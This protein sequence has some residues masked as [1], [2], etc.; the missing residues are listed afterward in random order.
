[1]TLSGV[2]SEVVPSVRAVDAAA[3]DRLVTADP[4]GLPFLR[5][6][7]LA[8]LEDTGCTGRQ[9]GW[10]PAHLLLRQGE[11]LVGLAPAHV[12][13]HSFGEF[14]HD[15]A[16]ADAAMRAGL[17]YYPKLVIAA[18]F[19][20]VTG[21]RLFVDPTLPEASRTALRT[22]LLGAAWD[23]ARDRNLSGVHLLFG[24]PDELA[25]AREADFA[26]RTGCQFHWRNAGE[27]DFAGFLSRFPSHRR[28]QIRRE[29]RQVAEAGV[30]VTHHAGGAI[31]DGW[32]DAAFAFYGATV[33]RYVYG[34]R[35]LNEA[36]FARLW[37][38]LREHLQLTLAWRGER[39]VGGALNVVHGAR[40]LGRYWGALEEVP[41]LHFEVC[42][43]AA[44]EDCLA[45]GVAVF[46]AGAGGE[47]H[48]LKRGFLPALTGSAHALVHRPLH[49]AV[50]DF[51]AREAAHIHAE[52]EVLA[53]DVFAR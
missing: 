22:A 21:R 45:S 20:P 6:A 34:R 9:S 38:D 17:R 3:W 48:K 15:S 46:E 26:L 42:A 8:A 27:G 52:A 47:S 31:E 41:A 18:P 7:F 29:R 13:H 33:D 51:C 39:I 19:S 49:D 37:S 2:T 32:R 53:H 44:I 25:L 35:Y 14:V 4:D 30:R 40:R 28:N 23:L 43:Y 11:A 36:F 5:H 50:A 24:L 16:W 12:K 10:E 1:M